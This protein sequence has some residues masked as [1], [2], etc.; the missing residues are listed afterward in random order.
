MEGEYSD[1][2]S[3]PKEIRTHLKDWDIRSRIYYKIVN[4]YHYIRS[5]GEVRGAYVEA[6]CNLQYKKYNIYHK[7]KMNFTYDYYDRELFYEDGICPNMITPE[8]KVIITTINS[9]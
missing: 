8:S 6:E 2:K 9:N 5:N 4:F 7:C 1:W 3:L